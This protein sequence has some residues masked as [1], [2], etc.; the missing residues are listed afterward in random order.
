[1]YKEALHTITT[2]Y[3]TSTGPPHTECDA[4]HTM[5]YILSM[6]ILISKVMSEV[7]N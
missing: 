7:A 6:M 4:L 5:E 1:M 2:G 3:K